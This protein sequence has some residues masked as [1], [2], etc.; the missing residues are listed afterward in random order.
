MPDLSFAVVGAEPQ[1][2][3]VAPQLVFK[4]QIDADDAGAGLSGPASVSAA[5]LR[6]QIRI[7]PARR[8]YGS[9]EEERLLDLFGTPER[10][11][12]TL[13][14]LLWTTPSLVVPAFTG[15]T[16][17][18]L[19]VTCTFDLNVAVTKYFYAL[20]EGAVP[21]CFLFSGTVFHV[22]P[23]GEEGN[24]EP[25]GGRLQASP[26]P[27]EKETSFPLPVP[28][29]MEMIDLYY[30]NSAWLCLREDVF[31]RLYLY[32]SRQGLPTWEEALERLLA[33]ASPRVS[34]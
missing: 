22:A 10:W 15:R 12:K 29:W 28:V 18:D 7:E 1:P 2:H 26:I 19:P 32:K 9:T 33:E 3:A 4:L 25:G 5:L 16:I 23:D 30:P 27:W 31:D 11:G 24:G 14:S 6:C 8:R 13:R 20:E 17:V 34:P 21:L